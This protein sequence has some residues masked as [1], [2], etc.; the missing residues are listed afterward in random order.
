VPPYHEEGVNDDVEEER[1]KRIAWVIVGPE[2]DLHRHDDGRVE[3]Q[4]RA[5]EEHP[6]GSGANC[7][8]SMAGTGAGTE[9]D[10]AIPCMKRLCG[11]MSLRVRYMNGQR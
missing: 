6:C 9:N 11:C 10:Q 1:R 5:A 2:T 8:R 7:E 4:R 3:K